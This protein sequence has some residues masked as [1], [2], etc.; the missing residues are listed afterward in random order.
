VEERNLSKDENEMSAVEQLELE[1]FIE[2]QSEGESPSAGED[3]PSEE[4]FVPSDKLVS[5]ERLNSVLAYL[6]VHEAPRTSKNPLM[7]KRAPGRPRKVER[8]PT[9]S[10]LEYHYKMAAEREKFISTDPIVQSVVDKS[11]PLPLF[12]KIKL[13][14]ACEAASLHF[15][16][17]ETEKR[18][19]DTSAISVRRIH[20]LER[21]AKIEMKIIEAD[22]GA[23]SLGGEK[24]QKVL[25]LWVETMRDV[26]KEV[27]PPEVLNLFF[28]R[29]ATAMEDWEERAESALR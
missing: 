15:E 16:R 29:F 24:M 20:A 27:M 23:L 14:I 6:P 17:I 3:A 7:V 28:N 8:M 5:D 21:L 4:D 18:G 9:T 12:H 13:A 1:K 22:R 26:A 10:D 2:E 19:R 25:A 11:E